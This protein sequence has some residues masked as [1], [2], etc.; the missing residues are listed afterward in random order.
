[1]SQVGIGQLQLQEWM[2]DLSNST[3][4]STTTMFCLL[5]MGFHLELHIAIQF[6]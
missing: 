3:N 5:S 4:S 6:Y 2:N 1:M